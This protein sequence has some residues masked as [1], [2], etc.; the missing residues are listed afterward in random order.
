MHV[1]LSPFEG[2]NDLT[3]SFDWP[4]AMILFLLATIADY[5]IK[6]IGIVP[7]VQQPRGISIN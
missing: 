4:N 1:D 2:N 5:F 3:H 6:A 7:F